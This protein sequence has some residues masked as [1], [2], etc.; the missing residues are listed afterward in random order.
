[1]N[2]PYHLPECGMNEVWSHASCICAQLR[3]CEERLAKEYR[4]REANGAAW[5]DGYADGWDSAI[6]AVREA[7]DALPKMKIAGNFP[8]CDVDEVL[9]T[10]DSLRGE[11]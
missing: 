10:I 9:A 11:K 6:F 3:A 2:W 5:L 8:L 7:V 1:M 4:N